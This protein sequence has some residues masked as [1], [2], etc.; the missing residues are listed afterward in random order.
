MLLPTAF[1]TGEVEVKSEGAK[2]GCSIVHLEIR[3]T[4]GAVCCIVTYCSALYSINAVP[5]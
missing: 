1:R 3:D 4:T 5:W 2:G